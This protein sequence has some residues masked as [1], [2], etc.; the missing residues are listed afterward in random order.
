MTDHERQAL[1]EARRALALVRAHKGSEAT[2][3]IRHDQ[4]GRIWI[5]TAVEGVPLPAWD[6]ED[7]T[8]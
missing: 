4:G 2:I 5:R 3:T 1:D 6:G 7:L 8:A